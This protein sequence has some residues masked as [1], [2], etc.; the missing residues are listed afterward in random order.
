MILCIFCIGFALSFF[1]AGC[2]SKLN[3]EKRVRILFFT[4]VLLAVS[5]IYKQ[6]ILCRFMYGYFEWYFF[7]F[8]L[9]SVPMYLCLLLPAFF[10][11]FR[12]SKDG[13]T[14][15]TSVSSMLR[16]L[17]FPAVITF[18][19]TY[20]LLGAVM[21]FADPSGMFY[22]YRSLTAHSFL[23]HIILI[24]IGLAARSIRR[25]NDTRSFAG[26]TVLFLI[27]C[28]IAELINLAPF[29]GEYV[30]MFYISPLHPSSQIVFCDIAARFGT[31]TGIICYI[32]S[33]ILGAW[34]I[35]HL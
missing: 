25:K 33:I 1:L 2:V 20:T 3:I 29:T 28:F 34:V 24:F 21:V 17:C 27:C 6:Y 18:L 22:P 10:K 15:D 13:S 8:Q 30:D 4:G 7:P 26:A 19:S 23:W 9:C 35:N 14:H 32:L 11:A 31:I 16:E 5:E 12:Q